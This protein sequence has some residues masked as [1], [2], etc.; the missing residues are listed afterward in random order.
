MT[1]F[2]PIL[3]LIGI[4]LIADGIGSILVYHTQPWFPDHTV[5]IIRT[6]LGV[7]CCYIATRI[8]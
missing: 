8:S 3:F 6:G 4:I 2:K 1:I 5:R 7:A